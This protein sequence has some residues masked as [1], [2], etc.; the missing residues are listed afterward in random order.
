VKWNTV[1]PRIA[2]IVDLTGDGKTAAKASAGRYYYVLSTGGGGVTNVNP[3]ANY[4]EQYVWND[5][6]GDHKFQLGEQT[7]TPVVTAVVVNGAILTSIDPN[8]SRPYTD[9]YSFAID[10]ELA[11]NFKLSAV[12]TYRREKNTQASANPD[13]PY[14]TTLSTAVDPGIDGVVGTADDGTYGFYQ[15]L[16]A[17]NRVLITNDPNVLQSYKGLELTLTKRF[18]DRWQMLAGYT[19]SVNRI[20]NISID[21]SPNFL[22]NSSGVISSDANPG[23]GSSR[24]SGCGASNGDKPNQFK[25]TGMYILPWQEIITSVNYSG[26]SGPAYTRQISRAL[27]IGGSQT[28][29]LQPMGDTRLDFQN[30]ID[31]RVGKMFKFNGSR[32]LEA[33]VDFDNLTNA[34]WVWQAR[35]LTPATTFT[36][37]TTGT[38]ATLQQFL[39]PVA[40]LGPRTVVFRAALKF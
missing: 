24:C 9:E 11:A 12:Y 30:R 29:N 17:A 33:T 8:F 1:G 14:A 27:A 31:V 20:D 25:L 21:V 38:R 2:G 19:T 3:N 15:R 36:D 22:I 7:G 26:V 16:S 23:G 35:S 34:N 13:N 6:N 5:L 32:T 18:T 37:P 28:I 10:R 40:I 39:S 4:S